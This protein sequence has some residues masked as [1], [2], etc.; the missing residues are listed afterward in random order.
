MVVDDVF[1]I[2]AVILV[3]GVVSLFV[4]AA[5]M[6]GNLHRRVLFGSLVVSRVVISTLGDVG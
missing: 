4:G 5:V 1:V 3:V 2:P 6:V